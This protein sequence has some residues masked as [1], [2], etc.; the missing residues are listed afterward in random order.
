VYDASLT[1]Q[2]TLNCGVTIGRCELL[3]DEMVKI[4]NQVRA[5]L[6]FHDPY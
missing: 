5:F 1:S 2:G 6:R 4:I 3:D